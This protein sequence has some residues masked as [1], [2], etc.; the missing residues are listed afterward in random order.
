MMTSLSNQKNEMARCLGLALTVSILL[1]TALSVFAQR[2]V[3]EDVDGQ[4]FFSE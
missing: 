4:R 1:A 3:A 2:V